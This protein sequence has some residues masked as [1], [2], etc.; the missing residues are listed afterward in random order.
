MGNEFDDPED[1]KLNPL[2][3]NENDEEDDEDE[4][5]EDEGISFE[6]YAE[7][8]A[9]LDPLGSDEAAQEELLEKEGFDMND[10][11]FYKNV[12]EVEILTDPNKVTLFAEIYAKYSK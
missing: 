11:E 1:M 12:W 3:E 9:K 7:L 6:K 8:S 4:E 10:W 2:D 5:D